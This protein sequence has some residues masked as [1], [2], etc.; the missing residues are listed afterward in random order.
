MAKFQFKLFLGPMFAGKTTKLIQTIRYDQ[1]QLSSKNFVLIRSQLDTR[2]SSN[3]LTNHDQK[4][5][6]IKTIHKF[7]Q[8][9]EIYQNPA[10]KLKKIYISEIQFLSIS[11]LIAILQFCQKNN[12]SIVAEG[13]ARDYRNQEFE[14]IQHLEP[15]QPQIHYLFA[16]CEFCYQK[17]STSFRYNTKQSALF[18]PGGKEFYLALCQNCYDKKTSSN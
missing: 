3:Q 1:K 16:R 13:L 18:L 17:A 7:D 5:L 11:E 6:I 9:V 14:F 12:L 8:L 2:S 4:N 15:F 10:Y